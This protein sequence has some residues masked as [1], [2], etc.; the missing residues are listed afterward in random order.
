MRRRTGRFAVRELS[1]L[2]DLILW[3]RE[4][5]SKLQPTQGNR[6][7][8][9]NSQLSDCR[10]A[11]N[12]NQN[13]SGRENVGITV[14]IGTLKFGRGRD[15]GPQAIGAGESHP[16]GREETIEFRLPPNWL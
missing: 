9:G 14:G 7:G 10:R 13:G 2:V 4:E 3:W 5:H 16:A 12:L 11:V 6:C 8:I 15:R 1:R